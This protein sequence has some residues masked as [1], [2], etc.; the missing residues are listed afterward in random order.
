MIGT[1]H[2]VSAAAVTII[3]ITRIARF[4]DSFCKLSLL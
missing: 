2:P 3:K 1:L 4:V